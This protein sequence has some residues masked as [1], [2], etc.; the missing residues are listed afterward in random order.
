MK[1]IKSAAQLLALKSVQV[2]RKKFKTKQEYSKEMKR[3]VEQR[4]LKVDGD[5][6]DYNVE[7]KK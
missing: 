4:W 3:R 5:S 2:T 1:N 6:R 7:I